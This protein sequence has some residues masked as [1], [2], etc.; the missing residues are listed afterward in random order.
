MDDIW[1]GKARLL[2]AGRGTVAKGVSIYVPRLEEFSALVRD[3]VARP[4]CQVV[5]LDAYDLIEADGPLEFRRK[6]LGLK[7]AVWYG[8]FTGGVRGRIQVFDR[9]RVVIAPATA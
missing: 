3:A 5:A 6:A 4:E 8:L 9:D 2:D 7:P 1:A